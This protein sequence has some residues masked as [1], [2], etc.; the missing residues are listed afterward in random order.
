MTDVNWFSYFNAA[1]RVSILVPEGWEGA[2]IDAGFRLWAPP[3]AEHGDDRP[4]LS[5]RRGSPEGYAGGID[6]LEEL[7]DVSLAEMVR[8]YERFDW[9]AERRF[10][11]SSGTPAFVRRY[12]WYSSDRDCTFAQ[13][14]AFI[15]ADEL[16][17]VNMATIV[18]L[19]DPYLAI[20]EAI[21]DSTRVIPAVT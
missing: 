19:A 21:L 4:S 10:W 12:E 5:Y 14:Q 15:D 11:L 1:T 6:G 20:F 18:E 9:K 17:R 2:D 16:I 13:L 7:I 3:S 8:E